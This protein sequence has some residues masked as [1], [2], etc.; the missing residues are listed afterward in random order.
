M[1]PLHDSLHKPLLVAHLRAR[2]SGT[3]QLSADDLLATILS[4]MPTIIP[5][6]EPAFH[7]REAILAEFGY[8]DCEKGVPATLSDGGF[9]PYDPSALALLDAAEVLADERRQS[10]IAPECLLAAS[11][12]TESRVGRM[13]RDL[14]IGA[15]ALLAHADT[16]IATEDSKQASATLLSFRD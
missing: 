6:G 9:V 10:V 15:D 7:L 13:M 3:R 2:S 11:I 14:G 16:R 4:L 8:I 1:R 12:S 5:G